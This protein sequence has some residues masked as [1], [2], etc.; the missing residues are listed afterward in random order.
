MISE[1]SDQTNILS[2]N[3]AIEAARAGEQGRGFA[4]VADEVGKLALQTRAASKQIMDHEIQ[5]T[6]RAMENN[7]EMISVQVDMIQKGGNAIDEIVKKVN[8]TEAAALNMKSKFTELYKETM[9][10]LQAIQDITGITAQSAAAAVQIASSTVEQNDTVD[11]M[12][13]Y[14]NQLSNLAENLKDHVKIFKI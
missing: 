4:V 9:K 3:A 8:R 13:R 7:L 5:V 11:E 2:L 6:I 1:I 14:V 12:F 10:I